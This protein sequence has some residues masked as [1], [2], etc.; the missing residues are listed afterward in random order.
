MLA[1]LDRVREAEVKAVAAV[2]AGATETA[3]LRAI[4]AGAT[5]IGG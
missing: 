5:V 2:D 3:K 4:M 1:A